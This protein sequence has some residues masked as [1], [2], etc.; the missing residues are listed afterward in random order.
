MTFSKSFVIFIMGPT[1]CGKTSFA[2]NLKKILPIEIISVDSGLIYKGMNI[3]TAK[4]TSFELLKVPH[5][6]INIKDPTETYSVADFFYDAQ[7]EVNSIQ[8]RGNIPVFVGGTMLYY[9]V[10]LN[11][12]KFSPKKSIKLR[13]S[14]ISILKN[15]GTQYIYDFLKKR[16][17]KLIKKIHPHD[18]YRLFRALELSVLCKSSSLT[19]TNADNNKRFLHNICQFA[20]IPKNKHTLYNN[21]KLR[22]KIMLESGFEDE[23]KIILSKK[24]VHENLPSMRCVGYRQMYKYLTNKINYSQLVC[25]IMKATVFLAKRQ[26]TWIRSWSSLYYLDSENKK[27]AI[28]TL[29]TILNKQKYI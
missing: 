2:I 4:P 26:M 1:A 14:I 11:G 7:R 24:N 9:K 16:N 15:K 21:I 23:V 29:L 6:L 12:L 27:L 10:L 20:L 19:K 28:N 3:G 22:L 17:S 13:K 5:K 25:E 8:H 18:S